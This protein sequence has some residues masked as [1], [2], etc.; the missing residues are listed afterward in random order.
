MNGAERRAAAADGLCRDLFREETMTHLTGA[1][2]IIGALS[3]GVVMFFKIMTPEIS[4]RPG[5]T[6]VIVGACAVAV[7]S[8]RGIIRRTTRRG[9]QP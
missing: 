5:D 3:L 4:W 7:I 2:I 9:L 6:E 8:V 1:T